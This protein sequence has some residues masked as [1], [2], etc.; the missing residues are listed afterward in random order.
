MTINGLPLSVGATGEGVRDLQ[1]RL[2][3]AGHDTGDEPG[4]YGDLTEVAVRHFQARRGLVQ[5]G[6]CGRDTWAA[7]IEAGFDLGDRLLYLRRPMLR[8]DDVADLQLKLASLGFDPGRVDGIFGPQ[9]ENALADFQRNAGLTTDGVCGP[10]VLEGLARLGSKT[11]EAGQVAGI[12]ERDRHHRAPRQLVDQRIV[13]GNLGGLEVP[14]QAIARV[15][16]DAGAVVLV[17][18][19]PDRSIQAAEANA[20]AADVYLGLCVSKGG[21]AQAAYYAT[22][23]FASLGGRHLARLLHEQTAGGVGVGPLAP[24]GMRIPVLRETRMPAVVCHLTAVDELVERHPEFAQAVARAVERW[25]D[26]PIDDQAD[27]QSD[28]P[29]EAG[30]PA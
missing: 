7:L 29:P 13:V 22:T 8:G 26:E 4:T 25:V 30:A 11:A 6:I 18:D 10:D 2:A 9:T 17:T 3:A 19:H 24:T 15:L 14:A 12:R 20:F 27:D 16:R 5:D 1:Q 28:E 23:G 21:T